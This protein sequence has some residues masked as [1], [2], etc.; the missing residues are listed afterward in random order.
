MVRV[1]T[2]RGLELKWREGGV[3]MRRARWRNENANTA[4]S[5]SKTDWS[6]NWRCAVGERGS[7]V[8]APEWVLDALMQVLFAVDG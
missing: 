3:E 2:V 4:A 1:E 7:E 6:K 8:T 5:L